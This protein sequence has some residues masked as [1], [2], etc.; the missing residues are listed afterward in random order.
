VAAYFE[1]P[2][3][4]LAASAPLLSL[5]AP[6]IEWIG[7]DGARTELRLVSPRDA[8]RL[9]VTLRSTAAIRAVTIDGQHVELESGKTTQGEGGEHRVLLR[10]AGHPEDGFAVGVDADREAPL[11]VAVNDRVYGLPAELTGADGLPPRPADLRP[12]R[13]AF[14]DLSLVHAEA[15]F[16]AES[17]A[18]ESEDTP[19]ED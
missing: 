2:E 12:S 14:S 19:P 17:A 6:E 5:P 18:D 11:S 13:L 15:T 16:A 1:D 3:E 9:D 7:G 8:S 4:L 10:L